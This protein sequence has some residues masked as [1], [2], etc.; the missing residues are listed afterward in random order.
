MQ[1][2]FVEKFPQNEEK[3]SQFPHEYGETF[4]ISTMWK[5]KIYTPNEFLV[6]GSQANFVL[7]LEEVESTINEDI[8]TIAL[9]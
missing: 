9:G 4:T 7:F 3:L 6:F 5:R 8:S 2:S 1:L